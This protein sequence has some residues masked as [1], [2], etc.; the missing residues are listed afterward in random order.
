MSRM[1]GRNV[2]TSDTKIS[3]NLFINLLE[4][5]SVKYNVT[6]KLRYCIAVILVSWYY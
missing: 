6:G 4:F 3:L 5:E 1:P 2:I